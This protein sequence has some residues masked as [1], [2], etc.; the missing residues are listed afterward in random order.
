[1]PF[2]IARHTTSGVAGMAMCLMPEFAQ[3]VDDRISP[4][5]AYRADAAGLARRPWR[6]IGWSW[7]AP[8]WPFTSIGREEIRKPSAW[9]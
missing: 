9:R 8:D 5:P 2:P 6:P 3:R 7:S 4:P 1:L